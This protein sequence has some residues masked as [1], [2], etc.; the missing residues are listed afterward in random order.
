MIVMGFK[1]VDGDCLLSEK[2]SHEKIE[3]PSEILPMLQTLTNNPRFKLNPG[4]WFEADRIVRKWE[5]RGG[6]K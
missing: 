3:K 2:S 4:G 5:R 1:R 6:K